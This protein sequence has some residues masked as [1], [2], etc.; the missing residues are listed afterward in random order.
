M[1]PVPRIFAAI[2]LTAL[3]ACSS[4]DT[5]T[6]V[7]CDLE[8][9]D[10]EFLAGMQKIGAGGTTFT[11]TSAT[12]SPPGRDDNTWVIDIST[13]SGPFTGAVEVV[14]FMPDHRHGTPVEVIVTPDANTPGRF[15]ATPINLWMPSLWEITVRAT[16]ALGTADSAVFRFCIPG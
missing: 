13:T 12:P 5:E 10:D 6:P 8:D 15:T 11:L 3:A 7:N 14:P 16:P 2:T 1:T 4:D 9:R